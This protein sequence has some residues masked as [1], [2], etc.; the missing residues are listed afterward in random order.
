MSRP[1]PTFRLLDDRVGWDPHPRDGLADVTLDG[2]ALRLAPTTSP[3]ATPGA[4]AATTS[5]GDRP[6]LVRS[7]DG[8]WW[9]AGQSGL[10]Q[11]GL[12]DT[13]FRLW[14]EHRAIRD[15]VVRGRRLAL[16][17]ATGLL[18][19]FDILSGR[20]LAEETV[21]DALLVELDSNGNLLITDRWGRRTGLDPSGLICWADPPCRPGDAVPAQPALRRSWPVDVVSGDHGF[22]LPGRGSYDWQGQPLPSRDVGP[23]GVLL[24]R[25]GQFLS[26]PLDSG[27][28]GC[29]WHRIRIDADVPGGC[30]PRGRL[31]HDGWPDPGA[32]AHRGGHRPVERLLTGRSRIPPTGSR[33]KRVHWIAC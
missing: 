13:E 5:A 31:C 14:R 24:V 12:G 18:E 33:Y 20:M 22:T 8:A 30:R 1:S 23:T 28:P 6:A 26:A 29:R 2:G 4:A 19:V 27:I 10:R 21:A 15:L 9:L 17:T 3:A 25:R 11:L 32:Y 16:V 7:Q